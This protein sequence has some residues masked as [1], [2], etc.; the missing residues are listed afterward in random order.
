MEERLAKI[1]DLD[2]HFPVDQKVF[3]SRETLTIE[4]SIDS[5]K[6]REDSPGPN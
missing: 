2:V 1:R 6:H 3:K 5:S 4:F